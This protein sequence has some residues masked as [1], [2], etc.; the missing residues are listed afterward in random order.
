MLLPDNKVKLSVFISD[1]SENIDDG[2]LPIAPFVVSSAISVSTYMH[3]SFSMSLFIKKRICVPSLARPM[4]PQ[5][6]G[7][8]LAEANACPLEAKR[9]AVC[10]THA[11]MVFSLGVG[12]NGLAMRLVQHQTTQYPASEELSIEKI[13]FK[14]FDLGGHQIA[15]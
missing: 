6:L 3:E 1:P 10:S 9:R 12:P 2:S 15:R 7:V 4:S 8:E 11:S 13:K 5:G 14:A